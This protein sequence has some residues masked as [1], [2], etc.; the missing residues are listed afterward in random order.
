V[1][2]LLKQYLRLNGRLLGFNIDPDFQDVLDGLIWVDLT[3]ADE[4][5]LAKFFGK[6]GLRSFLAYHEKSK[7]V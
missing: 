1:P 5:L 7:T 2:I 4:R 3:E 6:E